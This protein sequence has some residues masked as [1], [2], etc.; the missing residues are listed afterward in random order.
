MQGLFKKRGKLREHCHLFLYIQWG[1]QLLDVGSQCI[2]KEQA[3]CI[4]SRRQIEV[5][6][7]EE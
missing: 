7:E 3:K 1:K 5:E 6:V 2:D 4:T